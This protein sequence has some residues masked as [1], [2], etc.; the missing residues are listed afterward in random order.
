M[1]DL[2]R[3]ITKQIEDTALCMTMEITKIQLTDDMLKDI[4][5]VD[6]ALWGNELV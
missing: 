4:L 5:K 1:E 2:R 3:T 6:F